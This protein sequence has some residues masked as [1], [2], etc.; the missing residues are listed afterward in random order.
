MWYKLSK[1]Y[2]YSSV[3]SLLFPTLIKIKTPSREL[4]CVKNAKIWTFSDPY[5]PVYGQNRIEFSGIW[6]DSP[7]LSN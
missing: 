7:F 4:H 3:T 2:I 6:T 1:K 5:F